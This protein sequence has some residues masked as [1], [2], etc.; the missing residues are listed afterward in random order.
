MLRSIL[1]KAVSGRRRTA[2]PGAATGRRTTPGTAAGGSANS[3][4]AKGAS[5]LA[6]GLGRKRKG[7]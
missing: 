3:E 6:R 5:S 2:A 1:N 4:I 7:L